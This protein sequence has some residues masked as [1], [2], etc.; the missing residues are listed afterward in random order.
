MKMKEFG[1]PGGAR[2]PGA[3]HLDPRM[4]SLTVSH[5]Y[6]GGLPKPPGCGTPWMQNPPGCK[7]PG[8][9]APSPV[10]RMTEVWTFGRSWQYKLRKPRLRAVITSL[11]KEKAFW[12]FY[13][14]CISIPHKTFPNRWSKDARH[15]RINHV[16]YSIAL[17]PCAVSI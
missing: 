11:H 15:P 7:S 10:D 12:N 17:P 13:C 1:S 9:R 8:C 5:S 3:P 14:T 2:I 6:Q 16:W 4:H